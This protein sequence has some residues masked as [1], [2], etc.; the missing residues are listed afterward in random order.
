MIKVVHKILVKKNLFL[1]CSIKNNF[2]AV[3]I[4]RSSRNFIGSS[5]FFF[6]SGMDVVFLVRSVTSRLQPRTSVRLREDR[7]TERS[8]QGHHHSMES[9]RTSRMASVP[10]NAAPS[11]NGPSALRRVGKGVVVVG[12]GSTIKGHANSRAALRAVRKDVA[13]SDANSNPASGRLC[14]N[15]LAACHTRTCMLIRLMDLG[16]SRHGSTAQD[17]IYK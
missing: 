1:A 10:A 7:S 3:G 8:Q 13:V 9:G 17:S 4:F 12:D 14:T 16:L 11:T 2:I 5:S 6:V 15:G